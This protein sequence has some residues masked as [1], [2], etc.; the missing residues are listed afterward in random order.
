MEQHWSKPDAKLWTKVPGQVG[1]PG[2]R[3]RSPGHLLLE[4]LDRTTSAFK[5]FEAVFPGTLF[6]QSLSCC[7]QRFLS[8]HLLVG[9]VIPTIAPLRLFPPS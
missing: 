8:A 9:G 7:L 3:V 6:Q 5:V 4:D 2:L 1:G